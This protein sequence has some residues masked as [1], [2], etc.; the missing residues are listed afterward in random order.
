MLIIA[1]RV[2]ESH[3]SC[4]RLNFFPLSTEFYH[5]TTSQTDTVFKIHW[6]AIL[7]CMYHMVHYVRATGLNC[8]IYYHLHACYTSRT[9]HYVSLHCMLVSKK[10]CWIPLPSH[11]Q[12]HMKFADHLISVLPAVWGKNDDVTYHRT[13]D[14]PPAPI[15]T[16]VFVN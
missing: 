1:Q 12:I 2:E 4:A 6:P 3:T 10:C 15:W 8:C 5:S 16:T 11:F 9:H 14:F 13:Q 7:S